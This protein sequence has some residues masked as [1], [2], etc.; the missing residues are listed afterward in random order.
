MIKGG[1]R[2]TDSPRLYITRLFAVDML[3][4]SLRQY[5]HLAQDMTLALKEAEAKHRTEEATD[6]PAPGHGAGDG[7]GDGDGDSD[8]DD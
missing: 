4:A 7:D 1:R 3:L 6:T 8:G 5:L 2:K